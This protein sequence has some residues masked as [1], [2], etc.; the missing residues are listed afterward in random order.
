MAAPSAS[1]NPCLH[2]PVNGSA[3]ARRARATLDQ[4]PANQSPRQRIG[5]V[6]LA[7]TNTDTA[8]ETPRRPMNHR[9]V[10]TNT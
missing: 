4:T 5:T 3:A 6:P 8:T 10:G 1:L 9:E 2:L 7:D